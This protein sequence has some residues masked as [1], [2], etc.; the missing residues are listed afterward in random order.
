MIAILGAT[1]ERR[2]RIGTVEH[3]A[4]VLM[5]YRPLLDAVPDEHVMLV[6]RR[7]AGEARRVFLEE[8]VAARVV[9][10]AVVAPLESP[11]VSEQPIEA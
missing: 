7:L 5:R 11:A 8:C 10:D 1:A 6:A 9:P 4:A 2:T 3:Y